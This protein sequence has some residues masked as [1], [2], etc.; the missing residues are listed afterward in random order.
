[1]FFGVSTVS[2]RSWQVRTRPIV[3]LTRGAACKSLCGTTLIA[4]SASFG[5]RF[6]TMSILSAEEVVVHLKVLVVAVS[7]FADVK[8]KAK[9]LLL[10]RGKGEGLVCP[11][12]LSGKD[13]VDFSAFGGTEGKIMALLL[14]MLHGEISLGLEFSAI[15]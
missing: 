2:R 1:M 4:S 11:I 7:V 5:V 12:G 10:N 13:I 14:E 9:E 3:V 8:G 15:S 6:V